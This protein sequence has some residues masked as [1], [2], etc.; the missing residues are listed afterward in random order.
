MNYERN[1]RGPVSGSLTQALYSDR[2]KQRLPVP[3]GVVQLHKTME[4]L[5]VRHRGEGYLHLDD[6]LLVYSWDWHLCELK[7]LMVTQLLL[8]QD[9]DFGTISNEQRHW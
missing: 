2:M 7:S 3:P 9:G 5:M 6:N 8:Y 1:R 4:G